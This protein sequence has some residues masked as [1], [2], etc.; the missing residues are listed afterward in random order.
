MDPDPVGRAGGVRERR[1]E[2]GDR[3]HGRRKGKGHR[4]VLRLLF[5]RE[6]DKGTLASSFPISRRCHNGLYK[7]LN[8][9]TTIINSLLHFI[10]ILTSAAQR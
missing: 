3:R 6:G 9:N 1:R 7:Q 8:I 10:R 2:R 4:T 5:L